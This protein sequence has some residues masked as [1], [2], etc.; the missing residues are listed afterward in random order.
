MSANDA[1]LRGSAPPLLPQARAQVE[2]QRRRLLGTQPSPRPSA[3]SAERRLFCS[4]RCALPPASALTS[5]TPAPGRARVGAGRNHPIRRLTRRQGERKPAALR[6]ERASAA[7]T[8]SAS[9]AGA[10]ELAPT[11]LRTSPLARLPGR[12]AY[13]AR[14]TRAVA[15]SARQ[16]VR[17]ARPHP[18]CARSPAGAERFVPTLGEEE[19]D[20]SLP[21]LFATRPFNRPRPG[22][23]CPSPPPGRPTAAA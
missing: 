13:C 1:E 23:Q 6:K 7:H 14:R 9:P 15:A 3:G 16:V 19:I 21:E 17:A 4:A 18:P 20:L 11:L 5:L 2:S 22:R 10:G 12:V 8:S